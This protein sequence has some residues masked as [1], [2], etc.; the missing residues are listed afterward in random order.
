MSG[1]VKVT[2]IV[3]PYRLEAVKTAVAKLGVGGLT[4]TDV[5]G[6]GHGPGAA[7]PFAGD[8]VVA[9]HLYS[10]IEVAVSHAL[11]EDVASAIV[12]AARTGQSGDGMVF[13]EALVD[14]LR[15]RTE[16]RGPAAI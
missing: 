9:F 13:M 6:R 8:P 11:A 2:A 1:L 14:A 4:V 16:E 15:V 7:S 3:R 5:R 12:T 10:Q